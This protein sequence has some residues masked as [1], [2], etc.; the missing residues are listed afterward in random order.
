[1]AFLGHLG[2]NTVQKSKGKAKNPLNV[3]L[4]NEPARTWYI[5]CLPALVQLAGFYFR[6]GARAGFS[7]NRRG[8]VSP[9]QPRKN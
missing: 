8:S 5:A 7:T 6:G 9:S 2:L 1:V 3:G 4:A